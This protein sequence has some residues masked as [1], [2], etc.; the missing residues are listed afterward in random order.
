MRLIFY[1]LIFFMYLAFLF[2]LMLITIN[3]GKIEI[4]VQLLGIEVD[5]L[6]H[7]ALFFLI[8]FLH[9]LPLAGPP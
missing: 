5:K 4:P 3:P 6:V 8:L 9:G 7:F 1:K 2:C